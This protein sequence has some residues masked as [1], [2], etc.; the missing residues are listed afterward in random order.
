MIVTP[1]FHTALAG[2]SIRRV[3][4]IPNPELTTTNC[5]RDIL[6]NKSTFKPNSKQTGP[7]ANKR[8]YLKATEE[9]MNKCGETNPCGNLPPDTQQ[10]I[11]DIKMRRKLKL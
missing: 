8:T 3:S 10:R 5:V 6:I 1:N 2:T 7:P 4:T 11:H 9:M